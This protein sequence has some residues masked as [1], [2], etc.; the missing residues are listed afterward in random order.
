M[1]KKQW[2]EEFPTKE[3]LYYFYGFLYHSSNEGKSARQKVINVTFM[4]SGKNRK[5]IGIVD[6]QFVYFTEDVVG[7]WMPCIFPDTS[8]LVFEENV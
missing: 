1:S 2:S 5:L 8:R 3:G 6:N 4:G 7:F